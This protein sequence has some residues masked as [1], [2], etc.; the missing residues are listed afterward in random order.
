MNIKSDRKNYTI[1][2]VAEYDVDDLKER[3]AARGTARGF[4]YSDGTLTF[5]SNV[6]DIHAYKNVLAK[7]VADEAATEAMFTNANAPR[8]VLVKTGT[9]HVGDH[10]QGF[11]VTGLGRSFV[12]GEAIW[13]MVQ[14][15]A[16][17]SDMDGSLYRYA[18][19]K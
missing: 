11:V 5:L 19:F 16:D 15:P 4:R 9:C 18:Y 2:G 10:V 13:S 17:G 7:Y 8:R 14:R 1:T 3:L 12:P 6:N